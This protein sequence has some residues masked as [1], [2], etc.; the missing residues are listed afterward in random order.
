MA[1]IIGVM[2]VYLDKTKANELATDHVQMLSLADT[3]VSSLHQDL[4][5]VK[6]AIDAQDVK[7]LQT[8]LHTLKGYVTF[9]CH[10]PLARTLTQI[11][12]NA[13]VMG[14]PQLQEALKDLMPAL[15]GMQ[16]EVSQW[17]DELRQ[18]V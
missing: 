9:L 3:F 14:Y 16:I 10:E 5:Q 18:Q 11:E 1:D 4:A 6:Q 17:R 12:A 15:A 8:C 2:H 7:S 13:R